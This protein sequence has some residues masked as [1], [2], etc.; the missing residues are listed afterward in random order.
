[1]GSVAGKTDGTNGCGDWVTGSEPGTS[2]DRESDWLLCEHSGVASGCVVITNGRGTAGEGEGAGAGSATESGHSLR[3]GSG[4][5][6]TGEESGAQ[7][8]VSGDVCL[9]ERT[10]REA[11]LG[12]FGVAAS[13]ADWAQSGEIRYDADVGRDRGADSRRAGICDGVV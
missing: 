8:S 12:G 10:A 3:T 13:E 5:G 7:C 1:M 9:A 4:V 2:G 6:A 11:E